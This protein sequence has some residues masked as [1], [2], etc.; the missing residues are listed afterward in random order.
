MP[1]EGWH[2][3]EYRCV[4]NR[5]IT[6]HFSLDAAGGQREETLITMDYCL[7][8]ICEHGRLFTSGKNFDQGS[9]PAYKSRLAKH[10]G[11]SSPWSQ[12]TPPALLQQHREVQ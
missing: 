7:A 1:T 2:H 8:A 4:H 12:V 5:E 9:F 10:N 3:K 6:V 11:G